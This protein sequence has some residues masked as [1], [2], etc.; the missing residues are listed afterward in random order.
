M[1]MRQGGKRRGREQSGWE[2]CEIMP[3]VRIWQVVDRWGMERRG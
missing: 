1:E 3:W 2:D